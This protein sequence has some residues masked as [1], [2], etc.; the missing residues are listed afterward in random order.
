MVQAQRDAVNK[1][2]LQRENE[3]KEEKGQKIQ[4]KEKNT[5]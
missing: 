4:G 5:S 2:A 3:E 1:G